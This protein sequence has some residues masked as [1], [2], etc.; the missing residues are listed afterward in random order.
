M[1]R[2]DRTVNTAQSP[3]LSATS[4]TLSVRPVWTVSVG[5]APAA[6]LHPSGSL[7]TNLSACHIVHLR[8]KTLWNG[9]DVVQHTQMYS[10]AH[11]I[12]GTSHHAFSLWGPPLPSIS[13]HRNP[14]L[15]SIKDTNPLTVALSLSLSLS[16]LAKSV[17]TCPLLQCLSFSLFLSADSHWHTEN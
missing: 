12:T 1:D 2:A 4:H 17:L 7:L 15:P 8:G 10:K 13:D 5:L 14:R 3:V 9:V 6:V 16:V 11:S